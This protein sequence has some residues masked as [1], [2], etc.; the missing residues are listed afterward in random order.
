VPDPAGGI[1][2]TWLECNKRWEGGPHLTS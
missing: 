1:C 2:R